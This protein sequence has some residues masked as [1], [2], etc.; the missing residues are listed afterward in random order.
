MT[1]AQQ[2]GNA[3]L[4]GWRAKVAEHVAPA[5]A[6]RGP[7]SEDQARSIVGALF[8]ALSAYYVISTFVRMTKAA[9]G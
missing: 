4:V 3:G 6:K 9:R 5:A 2:L 1:H 8:F 7:L